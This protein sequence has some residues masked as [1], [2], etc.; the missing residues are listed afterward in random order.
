MVGSWL[1]YIEGAFNICELA[2]ALGA[3]YVARWPVFY[4][5]Q[6]IKSIKEGLTTEGFS[7]IELMSPCPTA[8]AQMKLH[9]HFP[10][11]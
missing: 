9:P 10:G 7:L 3:A 1:A 6:P 2:Q 8:Y 5:Y 11:N 4:P